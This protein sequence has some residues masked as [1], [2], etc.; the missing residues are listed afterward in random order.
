MLR[1][2]YQQTMSLAGSPKAPAWLAVVSF[3]E[4][5]VFPIPPDVVLAP[6]VLARPEKAYWYATLC[7]IASVLG[8]ILGYV[9]GYFLGDL[10]HALL[11]LMGHSEGLETF[12]AWYAEWGLWVILIKGATPIPYKLVTVTSGLA[13]FNFPVFVIASIVTRAARFFL[14]AFFLRQFGPSILPVIERRIYLV[15]GAFVGVLIL[16]F[17]AV[18]LS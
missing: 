4:S 11:A 16:G 14:V 10:G 12:Q 3:T 1:R 9:I 15:T 18:R 8:G 5:S 2:L 13:A 6:M 7:T 17:L